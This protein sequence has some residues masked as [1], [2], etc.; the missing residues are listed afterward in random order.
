MGIGDCQ[1]V[2]FLVLLRQCVAVSSDPVLAAQSSKHSAR[3]FKTALWGCV[4]TLAQDCSEVVR[5]HCWGGRENDTLSVGKSDRSFDRAVGW[6]WRWCWAVDKR[7]LLPLAS[8][9]DKTE[10]RVPTQAVDE[11]VAAKSTFD[12]FFFFFFFLL[13]PILRSLLAAI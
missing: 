11:V 2:P 12:F 6:R 13:L 1:K 10:S 4:R 3:W 8:A 7:P 9:R 5:T